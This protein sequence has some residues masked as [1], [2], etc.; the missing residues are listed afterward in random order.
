M[1]KLVTFMFLKVIKSA[2]EHIEL[3]RKERTHYHECLDTSS[4][5]IKASFP[6]VPSPGFCLPANSTDTTIHYS[7]DMAHRYIRTSILST[8]R[9]IRTETNTNLMFE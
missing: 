5:S 2:E 9:C 8:C 7:F 4:T 1:F 6:A 3:V